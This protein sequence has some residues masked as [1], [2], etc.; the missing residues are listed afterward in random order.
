[1][2]YKFPSVEK[3]NYNDFLNLQN[4]IEEFLITK[5]LNNEVSFQN[6]GDE[7]LII[8]ELNIY[9]NIKLQNILNDF[10][11]AK[12]L[13]IHYYLSY[14]KQLCAILSPL[15]P[16]PHFVEIQS[17]YREPISDDPF[18]YVLSKKELDMYDYVKLKNKVLEILNLLE[19]AERRYPKISLPRI[20]S[21]WRVRYEKFNPKYLSAIEDFVVEK[22]MCKM[23]D[24]ET[25]EDLCTKT[26]V[27]LRQLE[28]CE[29]EIFEY[30][31][32]K[33][34]TE[35]EIMEVVYCGKDKM[36]EIKKSACV[37]FLIPFRIKY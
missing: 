23:Q 27:A 1:M 5:K 19:Y 22:I 17:R 36:R 16:K 35:D 13:D 15:E 20:T 29:M 9:D 4:E 24:E 7:Y 21:D 8:R 26:T 6:I 2:E 37:K 12:G 31:F 11:L 30:T 10:L 14:Q 28:K 25:I 34:K 18:K 32:F 3:V 33:K